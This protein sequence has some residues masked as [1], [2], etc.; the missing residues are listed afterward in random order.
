LTIG[1]GE[2]LLGLPIAVPKG[3]TNSAAIW[4]VIWFVA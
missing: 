4:L 3:L 2:K 1:S